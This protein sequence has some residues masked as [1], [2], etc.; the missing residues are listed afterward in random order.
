[1]SRI[2]RRS[3]HRPFLKRGP[4]PCR[5]AGYRRVTGGLGT[6]ARSVQASLLEACPEVLG[7]LP[8][9]SLAGDGKWRG[10]GCARAEESAIM[11]ASPIRGSRGRRGL[12]TR[13]GKGR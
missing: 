11:E 7:R 8:W 13:Q 2:R 1:M 12:T 4:W 10:L 9:G 6:T 5:C 3:R